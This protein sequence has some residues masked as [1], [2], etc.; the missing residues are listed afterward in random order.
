MI[1]SSKAHRC[2]HLECRYDK[3]GRT[4]YSCIR[5][6]V[7]SYIVVLT[8]QAP[9]SLRCVFAVLLSIAIESSRISPL[10]RIM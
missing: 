7:E 2:S 9:R 5:T 8:A 1:L 10:Q 3:N 6:F 4:L